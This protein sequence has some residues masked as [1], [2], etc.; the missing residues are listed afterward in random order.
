MT[1]NYSHQIPLLRSKAPR[2]NFAV[3]PMPQLNF[4]QSLNYANYWAPTVS[5]FSKS[6]QQAWEFL[7]FLSSNEGV[8]SYLNNSGRPTARR[9]LIEQQKNDLDLGVFANQALSAV[10]WYQVDALAVENIMADMIED[11]NFGRR[12]ISE[13]LRTAENKINVLMQRR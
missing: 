5:K 4:S 10:S 6:G 13:A 8:V 1:F 12:S 2:L 9:E 7:V 3:A 11:V